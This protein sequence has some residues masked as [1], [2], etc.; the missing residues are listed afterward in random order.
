MGNRTGKRRSLV[1]HTA[2][3]VSAIFI[4]ALTI[5][6]FLLVRSFTGQMQERLIADKQT[7]V[8]EITSGV[9]SIFDSLTAPMVTMGR[10]G[11]VHKLLRDETTIYSPEWL[12]C[13]RDIQGN[14]LNVNLFS[15][16]IVDV[17]II[18]PDSTVIYSHSNVLDRGYDFCGAPWF[19]QAL[20]QPGALKHVPPHGNDHYYSQHRNKPYTF[21]V[22]FPVEKGRQV[23]GYV[24]FEVDIAKTSHIFRRGYAGAEEGFL[25]VEADGGVIFDY[26][27]RGDGDTAAIR[28]YLAAYDGSPRVQGEQLYIGQRLGSTGWYVLSETDMGVITQPLRHYMLL[29]AAVLLATVAVIILLVSQVARRLRGPMDRLIDR[30][31]RYDGTGAIPLEGTGG[32][33]GE[34]LTI[35]AKFEEMAD[36]IAALIGDVYTAQRLRRDMEL[37]ALMNQINPHFLY[38]VLQTI[39][40]EAVLAGNRSV[41]DM[42]TALGELLR[43]TMD[44]SSEEAALGEELAHLERFLGFY[45]ARFPELFTYRLA[46]PEALRDCVVLKLSLQPIV[47]NCFKH[48]FRDRKSGGLIEVTVEDDGGRLRICIRDNGRGMDAAALAGLRDELRNTRRA[49][50]IGLANT[51]VRIR[52]KYGEAYGLSIRS[53]QGEFTVVELLLPIQPDH[54]ATGESEYV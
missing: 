13:I 24:F 31:V 49:T 9:D 30:I 2:A 8:V 10:N 18:K 26:R 35:R 14:L 36:K 19:R 21:S 53:E 42:I 27:G 45:K 41:E 38:N 12:T 16:H 46:C 39:Q 54:G 20:E 47:E 40:G 3:T 23:I 1:G 4:G 17:A 43:Y 32:D 29:V 28:E 25:L 7:L 22:I 34:I 37:E 15:E 33:Y 52:L 11:S 6:A 50:G 51:N 44:R 5:L 48:G